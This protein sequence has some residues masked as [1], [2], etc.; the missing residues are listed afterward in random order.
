M[1]EPVVGSSAKPFTELPFT[2]LAGLAGLPP[3]RRA[4][5][6]I[7]EEEYLSKQHQKKAQE[8]TKK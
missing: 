7:V 5:T 1:K 8:N 6:R 4:R 2:G 3:V